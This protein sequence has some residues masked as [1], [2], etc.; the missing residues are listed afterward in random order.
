MLELLLADG[1][2]IGAEGLDEKVD[3]LVLAIVNGDLENLLEVGLGIAV[4]ILIVQHTA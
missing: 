4:N 2:H 3:R 1:E